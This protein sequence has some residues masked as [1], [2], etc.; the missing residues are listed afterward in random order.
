M[1][2]ETNVHY[3]IETKRKFEP[4]SAWCKATETC[5]LRSQVQAVLDSWRARFP[6]DEY[7]ALKVTV[8]HE[9]TEL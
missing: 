8:T 4:D 5:Y 1:L 6:A 3:E 9:E 2:P 7:R